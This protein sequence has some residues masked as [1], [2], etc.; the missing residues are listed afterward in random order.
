[1]SKLYSMMPAIILAAFPSFGQHVAKQD[2]SRFVG[3]LDCQGSGSGTVCSGAGQ[4]FSQHGLVGQDIEDPSAPDLAVGGRIVLGFLEGKPFSWAR[5]SVD[6]PN[7]RTKWIVLNELS[8][9]DQNRVAL[10]VWRS[11]SEG[12]D[13]Q[14]AF[15]QLLPLSLG[16]TTVHAKTALPDGSLLL[17][18]KGE[19]SD[20]GI[21]VQDY[22]FLRL[23]G[24]DRMQEVTRRTNRS[25]IP[26]QKILD[27]LNAQESV[28]PVMDS[29]LDCEVVKG[30]KAPSGGPLIVMVKK[31]NRIQY[32]RSGPLESGLGKEEEN[33]DIWARR[34]DFLGNY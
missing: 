14:K 25:E 2:F 32:T 11:S 31:R 18:L 17:I 10:T 9:N 24:S 34:R 5:Y 6:F 3:V 4:G 33:L 15:S 12:L 22:R 8:Q 28:E 1:M 20:A 29:T 16:E 13:F 27:R 19:G 21:N 26:V 30:R 7:P 23:S